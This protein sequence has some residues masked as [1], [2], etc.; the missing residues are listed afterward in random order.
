MYSISEDQYREV[1]ERLVEEVH[2]KDY[3]SGSISG[4]FHDDVEWHL[5]LAVVVYND[6]WAIND[7]VPVWWN[8]NTYNDEDELNNDFQFEE[9]RTLIKEY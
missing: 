2:R 7:I 6:G 5:E 1:M 8:F 4:V 3:Y 9:I